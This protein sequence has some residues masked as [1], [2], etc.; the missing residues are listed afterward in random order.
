MGERL[1]PGQLPK[2]CWFDCAS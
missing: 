1:S 2:L